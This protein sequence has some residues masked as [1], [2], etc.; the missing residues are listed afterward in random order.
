MAKI[1]LYL[2]KLE[3][4]VAGE[5]YPQARREEI[6]SCRNERVRAQKAGVWRLLETGLSHAFGLELRELAPT[7]ASNGKWT[8]PQCYFSL[9]HGGNSLAAALSQETVGVDLEELP[10][11]KLSQKLYDKIVCGQEKKCEADERTIAALW[12]KKEAL[13][14]RDGGAVFRPERIDTAAEACASF[15]WGN[16]VVSLSGDDFTA[17]RVE[18]DTVELIK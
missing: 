17:Y 6:A 16:A 9:S 15:V 2:A 3:D 14:K 18:G 1:Y 8:C 7:R 11:K 10:N 13:F 5:I 4:I 12:T